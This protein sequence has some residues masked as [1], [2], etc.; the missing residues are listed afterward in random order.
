MTASFY[1][2]T[3]SVGG[4]DFLHTL[5]S[6]CYLQT[7]WWS[8]CEQCEAIPLY[9][10]DLHFSNNKQCWESFHVFLVICMPLL[11]FCN[12]SPPFY[13][14]DKSFLPENLYSTAFQYFGILL[15]YWRQV[16]IS[17][18]DNLWV[19]LEK[20]MATHSSVLDWEI[21]WVEEPGW[22]L[23]MG[24]QELDTTE[25]LNHHHHMRLIDDLLYWLLW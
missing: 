16:H 10:F 2:P 18:K 20:K 22:L 25:R 8:Q 21:S 15:T 9:G 4:F 13:H 23:S 19:L 17:L 6:F 7:F 14:L 12:A 5:S 11:I 24:S 3:H 1:I